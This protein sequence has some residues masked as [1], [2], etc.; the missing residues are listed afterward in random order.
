MRKRT[1]AR[2]IALQALYQHDL[3][4]KRHPNVTAAVTDFEPFIAEATGDPAVRDYVRR[5]IDGVLSTSGELDRYI[6]QAAEN[7]KLNRIAP[8]DRSILRLALFEMLEAGDVPPKV[9]IDEAVELAK[10]FSTEQSGAFVNGILDRLWREIDAARSGAS[11]R[12]PPAV[13]RQPPAASRQPLS[14][15]D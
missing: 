2:E 13:E 10:K 5:L 8:V 9:A 7:W 4:R 12:Q 15:D 6:A 11:P 14:Q 1:L 3:R